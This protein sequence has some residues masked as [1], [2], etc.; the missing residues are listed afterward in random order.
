VQNGRSRGLK[1]PPRK[2][3]LHILG[4]LTSDIHRYNRKQFRYVN[5]HS[6]EQSLSIALSVQEAEKQE[7][8]NEKFYTQ[9]TDSSRLFSEQP[10][11]R[12][13]MT[14]SLSAHLT[15]KRLNTCVV[16]ATILHAVLSS[17]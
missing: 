8:L 7:K 13:A 4:Q 16:S 3:E 9:F 17:H 10:A 1:H 5:L 6:I 15:H 12:A 2:C 11:G 14:V